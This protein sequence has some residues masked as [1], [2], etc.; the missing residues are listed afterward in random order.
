MWEISGDLRV[1]E[2][3]KK[4]YYGA[5]LWRGFDLWKCLRY[6]YGEVLVDL[7]LRIFFIF[8]IYKSFLWVFIWTFRDVWVIFFF[9]IVV[10]SILG[11][12]EVFGGEGN[13]VFKGGWVGSR[14][15]INRCYIEV[16][17]E[18]KGNSAVYVFVLGVF[19]Y[20]FVIVLERIRINWKWGL[21]RGIEICY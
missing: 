21:Y 9:S 13:L 19:V 3:G 15:F 18:S 12:Y 20:I 4:D 1:G 14:G 8:F 10:F 17:E 6:F 11:C 2:R 7:L 16:G 5:S